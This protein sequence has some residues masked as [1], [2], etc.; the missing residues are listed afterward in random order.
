MDLALACGFGPHPS[1]VRRERE[2]P[3]EPASAC[4]PR[5][6]WLLV[7]HVAIWLCVA[8]VGYELYAYRSIRSLAPQAVDQA[9][10]CYA[11]L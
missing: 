4:G 10:R 5:S 3:T 6:V 9:P 11:R 8:V 2:H 1:G 7:P